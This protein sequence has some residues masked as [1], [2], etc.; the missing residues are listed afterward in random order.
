MLCL[1]LINQ[2]YEYYVWFLSSTELVAGS[3]LNNIRKSF[4]LTYLIYLN[5]LDWQETRLLVKAKLVFFTG[6]TLDLA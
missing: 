2:N 3:Q 1:C 4:I 5:C 6:I